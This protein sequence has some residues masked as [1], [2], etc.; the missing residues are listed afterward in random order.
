M[1]NYNNYSH[2]KIEDFLVHYY[3]STTSVLDVVKSH[4]VTSKVKLVVISDEQTKGRGRLNRPWNS[5]N[6]NLMASIVIPKS[7]INQSNYG[8]VN[9]I[10]GLIIS[11]VLID[12]LPSSH[13]V[14]L[15]W[16][17]DILIN[18][19][20]VSGILIEVFSNVLS[21][22]VGVNIT[23]FPKNL[24]YMAT[25]LQD[26]GICI[27]KFDFL[28]M[29]LVKFNEYFFINK[30]SFIESIKLWKKRC[31]GIGKQITV[32]LPNKRLIGTFVDINHLGF[33]TLKVGNKIH[34]INSGDVV[35]DFQ[36]KH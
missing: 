34:Y 22:G 2:L 14:H 12:I 29:L 26:C 35:Y 31:L 20:K 28:S 10:M 4:F 8:A 16:P 17:N 36:N 23:K 27:C 11:D 33:L 18:N 9:F 25:S 3:K 32:N 6:G 24:N 1:S 5:F 19:C 21:I 30:I 13:N 7:F 15:K